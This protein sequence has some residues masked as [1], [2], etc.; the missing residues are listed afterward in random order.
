MKRSGK[1]IPFGNDN[2]KGKRQQQRQKATAKAK[3]NSILDVN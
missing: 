3:G 1:Q 2:Q